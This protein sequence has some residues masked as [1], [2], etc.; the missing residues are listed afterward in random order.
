MSFH[1][2]VTSQDI[3]VAVTVRNATNG[4][5]CGHLGPALFSSEPALVAHFW[6]G[7][8]ALSFFS[9]EKS[10]TMKLPPKW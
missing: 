3:H 9:L 2:E 8:F 6:Q 4:K 1:Q 10:D 5:L 7:C